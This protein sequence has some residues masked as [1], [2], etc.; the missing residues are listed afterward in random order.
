M[1]MTLYI[2]SR[3]TDCGMRSLLSCESWTWTVETVLPEIRIDVSPAGP[4]NSSIG[5]FCHRAIMGHLDQA[6][7]L[8][9]YR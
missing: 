9:E 5:E 8:H 1:Y 6:A 2:L 3:R 4:Q 7:S